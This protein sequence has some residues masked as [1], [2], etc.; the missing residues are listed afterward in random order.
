MDYQTY[1]DD[2]EGWTYEDVTNTVSLVNDRDEDLFRFHL[3]SELNTVVGGS[4]ERSF[5][6]P[7]QEGAGEL[8]YQFVYDESG[9]A[10]VWTPVTV[11]QYDA[12]EGEIDTL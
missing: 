8:T 4:G 9:D 1:L 3:N 11:V 10:Y 5:S 7:Y 6:Y 12:T 2:S